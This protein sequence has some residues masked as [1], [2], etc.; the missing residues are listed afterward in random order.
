M[1]EPEIGAQQHL[2]DESRVSGVILDE[3]DGE[4][5]LVQTFTPAATLQ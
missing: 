1:L 5:L 4:E 2:A 3:Q